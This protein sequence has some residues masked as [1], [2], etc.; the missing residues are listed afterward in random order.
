VG[1]T[2]YFLDQYYFFLSTQVK[3]NS[4]YSDLHTDTSCEQFYSVEVSDMSDDGSF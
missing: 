3:S 4:V 2:L 1:N